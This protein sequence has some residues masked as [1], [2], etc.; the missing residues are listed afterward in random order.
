MPRDEVSKVEENEKIIDIVE[1]NLELNQEKHSG[2]G[3]KIL[4]P[5]QM[6]SRLAIT[7]AQLK[8][9]NNSEKLENEI[10]QLL[11]SLYRSKKLA[12]QLYKSLIY[13]I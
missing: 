6:L 7:L 13:I 3:F 1:R 11:Y 2:K 8:A 9:A 5:D 4:T 12:K 10:R